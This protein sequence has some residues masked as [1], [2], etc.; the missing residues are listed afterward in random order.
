MLDAQ[1][2]ERRRIAESLHNGLNQLLYATKLHLEQLVS[3]TPTTVF[4]EGKKKAMALLSDAISQGRTLSHQLMPT[5]LESFGLK[6]ALKSICHDLNS[7]K[8]H[9]SCSVSAF[10]P[11][12]KSL[13]LALYRMAQEL[14]NNV[15]KHADATQAHLHLVERDG[16]LE[17]HADDNGRG[18]DPKRARSQ[19]MGLNALRDRVKLLGGELEILSSP[20]HGTQISVRIPRTA[21]ETD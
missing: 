18:F 5:A 2:S 6:A 8:L 21:L 17:L 20:E 1:E 7:S 13:E 12:S 4:T 15:V 16:W 14:A 10:A 9:L 3:P 11:I 19:G